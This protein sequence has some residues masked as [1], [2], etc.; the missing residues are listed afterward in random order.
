MKHVISVLLMLLA[1]WATAQQDQDAYCN[2]LNK[3]VCGNSNC[4]L[5]KHYVRD[6]CEY[7]KP[8]ARSISGKQYVLLNPCEEILLYKH[9][10]KANKWTSY[11]YYFS[12]D[13]ESPVLKLTKENLKL[14]FPDDAEFHRK[15]DQIFYND[16]QLSRFDGLYNMYLVNWLFARVKQ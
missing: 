11:S 1:G 10:K 8:Y 6:C 3:A 16:S 14:V 7:K 15:L 12:Q 4:A 9:E 2:E 13:L 5:L